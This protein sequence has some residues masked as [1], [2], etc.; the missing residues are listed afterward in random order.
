MRYSEPTERTRI[1]EHPP[2]STCCDEDLVV[3]PDVMGH[4]G[5]GEPE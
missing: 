1:G 4:G 2:T 5:D 3:N